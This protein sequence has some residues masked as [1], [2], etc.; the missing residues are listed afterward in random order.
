MCNGVVGP[1][2]KKGN[3]ILMDFT[4]PNPNCPDLFW[5]NFSCRYLISLK[6]RHGS[7]KGSQ[8]QYGNRW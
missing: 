7:N 4:L 6:R 3:E 2:L 5:R 8:V 1:G